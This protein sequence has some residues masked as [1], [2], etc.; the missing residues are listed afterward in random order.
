MACKIV[1]MDGRKFDDP[2]DWISIEYCFFAKNDNA[3]NSLELL[4]ED[5]VVSLQYEYF[6]KLHEIT[7]ED[8]HDK[9]IIT[10]GVPFGNAKH[11]NLLRVL[12]LATEDLK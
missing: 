1:S 6:D 4:S 10:A 12:D 7:R 9:I 3:I 11:T 2:I 5:D 8:I